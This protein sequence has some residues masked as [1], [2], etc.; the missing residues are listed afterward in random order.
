MLLAYL[1]FLSIPRVTWTTQNCNEGKGSNKL[2]RD[3]GSEGGQVEEEEA[4]G[5]FLLENLWPKSSQFSDSFSIPKSTECQIEKKINLQKKYN[6]VLPLLIVLLKL[7]NFGSDTT[8]FCHSAMQK[9]Y[10]SYIIFSLYQDNHF[11]FS[12]SSGPRMN[13]VT[14]EI[15]NTLSYMLTK[16]CHLCNCNWLINHDQIQIF[17]KNG[18]F[19]F[20]SSKR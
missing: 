5:I 1:L 10:L 16:R 11:S 3:G 6:C 15:C 18:L 14:Q 7:M 17:M 13:N 20:L 2:I 8:T 9:T 12:F 19:H 4:E